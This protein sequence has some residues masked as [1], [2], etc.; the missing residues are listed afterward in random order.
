MQVFLYGLGD[1]G[2]FRVP[3]VQTRL[4]EM[5]EKINSGEDLVY[6]AKD[7]SKE[8]CDLLKRW[9]KLTE[10]PLVT[11]ELARSVLSTLAIEDE[12]NALDVLGATLQKLPPA[13][14]AVLK[15]ICHLAYETKI[16]GALSKFRFSIFVI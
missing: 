12:E 15:E 2:I 11:G 8:P 7:D 6:T 14:L 3:G 16:V 4:N 10:G 9:C 1:E 13:R 5:I